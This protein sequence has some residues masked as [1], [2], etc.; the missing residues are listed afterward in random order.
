MRGQGPNTYGNKTSLDSNG[1]LGSHVHVRGESWLVLVD[2][3][4]EIFGE[5][6]IE[7]D[8]NPIQGV[9][10]DDMTIMNDMAISVLSK[11]DE[12]RGV[13]EFRYQYVQDLEGA[14]HGMRPYDG[15]GWAGVGRPRVGRMVPGP[16][17]LLTDTPL[18]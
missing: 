15:R 1:G 18:R 17:I 12:D 7:V 13:L 14:R 5:G 8:G 11:F 6:L 9:E 16:R 4:V 2:E 3:V 10:L